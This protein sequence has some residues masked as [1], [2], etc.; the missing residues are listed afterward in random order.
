MSVDDELLS[1]DSTRSKVD[2]PLLSL[3]LGRTLVLPNHKHSDVV[4]WP[5]NYIVV[6]QHVGALVSA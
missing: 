4:V 5:N 2:W 1:S 6:I 3:A